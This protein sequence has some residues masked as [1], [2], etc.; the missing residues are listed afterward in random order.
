MRV[1]AKFNLINKFNN[2]HFGQTLLVP[3]WKIKVKG[4]G[5]QKVNGF[6]GKKMKAHA[7]GFRSNES[8]RVVNEITLKSI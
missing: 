1:F 3:S 8:E 5:T 2:V 4:F 6:N 7:K